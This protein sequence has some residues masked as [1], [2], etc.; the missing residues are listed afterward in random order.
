MNPRQLAPLLLP[1]LAALVVSA[2]RRERPQPVVMTVAR[3][4]EPFW[5]VQIRSDGMQFTRLGIDS[6][7]YPYTP[8]DF[9]ADGRA[10]YRS[11]RFGADP[12]FTLVIERSD[13]NDGMSDQRYPAKAVLTRG[14]STWLGCATVVPDSLSAR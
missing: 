3:G 8:P 13:C 14:D 7:Y 11:K 10:V 2:C 5:S 12:L 6:S 1:A 9:D 4:T